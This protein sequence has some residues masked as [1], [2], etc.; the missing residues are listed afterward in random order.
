LF[1]IRYD[2]L[3]ERGGKRRLRAEQAD[4]LLNA[5]EAQLLD[6]ART[7]LFQ[8]RQAFTNAELCA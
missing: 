7:Q 1:T 3:V 6:E 2:Q 5:G 4:F 8:L